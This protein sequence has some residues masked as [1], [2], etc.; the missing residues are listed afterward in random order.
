MARPTFDLLLI[1]DPTLGSGLVDQV[2]AALA[3]CHGCGRR[4]AV[5]LRAKR[6]S[7]REL[8]AAGR[9]L[10]QITSAAGSALLVN[11]R[12]DVA[13]VCEADGV[14]LP[15]AGMEVEDARRALGEAALIGVSRHDLHGIQRAA[16]AGADFA[17]LSPVHAVAGKGEALGISGVQRIIDQLAPPIP[18][19][20][21]GGVGP[22]DA[23]PLLAAGARGIAVIRA[24]LGQESPGK[25]T[26]AILDALTRTHHQGT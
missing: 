5:Q 15:E 14:Q 16:R 25:A 26:A 19:Y 9:A 7:T 17:T 4:V 6:L 22:A 13:R 1:T 21:L 11:D 2:G 8:V 20:A 12:L 18:V 23:Q 24:V 3:G 10:R